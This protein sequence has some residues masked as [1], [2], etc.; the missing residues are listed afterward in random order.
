MLGGTPKSGPCPRPR[1]LAAPRRTLGTASL[2]GTPWPEPGHRGRAWPTVKSADA[3]IPGVPHVVVRHGLVMGTHAARAAGS[4][5]RARS[6]PPSPASHSG[7]PGRASE[8]WPR[9]HHSGRPDVQQPTAPT[10]PPQ[11]ASPNQ[12]TDA[13]PS[14]YS[15]GRARG[16]SGRKCRGH[17]R[18]AAP[19]AAGANSASGGLPGG[20]TAASDDWLG[21]YRQARRKQHSRCRSGCH[22]W[23]LAGLAG[24]GAARPARLRLQRRRGAPARAGRAPA[25][26]STAPAPAS[27]PRVRAGTPPAPAAGRGHPPAQHRH[28]RRPIP[29]KRW[30]HR[31]A[32]R[33]ASTPPGAAI[34]SPT[35][36]SA[37]Q[38]GGAEDPGVTHRSRRPSHGACRSGLDGDRHYQR[39]RGQLGNGRR[40]GAVPGTRAARRRAT[41][42]PGA[43]PQPR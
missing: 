31:A 28:W 33:R 23:L 38:P 25:P 2:P 32:R 8:R 36:A 4:A 22:G 14:S 5:A 29:H 10:A 12:G 7:P 1:P 42:P 13:A 26:A 34:P 30:P 17:P 21:G 40:G 11:S 20:G 18:P 41:P 27:T 19:R 9:R 16:Q 6:R 35:A 43:A 24:R 37:P 3:A 39:G 15:G